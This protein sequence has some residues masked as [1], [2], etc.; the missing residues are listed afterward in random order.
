MHRVLQAGAKMSATQLVDATTAVAH[1][2]SA[3]EAHSATTAAL[4]ELGWQVSQQLLADVSTAQLLRL[5]RAY[6]QAGVPCSRLRHR[7]AG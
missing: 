6:D 4:Q 3:S 7:I 1:M 2:Y 5:L